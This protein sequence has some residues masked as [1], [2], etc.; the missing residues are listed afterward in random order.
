MVDVPADHAVRAALLGLARDGVLKLVDI[1]D[2]ALDLVLEVAR[3]APV[4]QAALGADAVEPAVDLQRELVGQVARDGQPAR[5][6]DDAVVQVTMRDPQLPAVGRHMH[7]LVHHVDAAEVVRDVF[8]RELVVVA[9]D[10]DDPRALARLAQQLLHDVVVRLRPVPAAAQLPAVDDV[11]DEVEGLALHVA[12][13][14]EQGPGLA[15]GRAQ[16]QV[17]DPDGAHRQRG[18]VGGGSRVLRRRHEW[19]WCPPVMTQP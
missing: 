5:A 11:A 16:M 18:R 7:G 12:Q 9:R 4:R 2:R 3:Q 6:L 14:V 13:E 10:E 19:A 15:A 17:R 8:A 1:A